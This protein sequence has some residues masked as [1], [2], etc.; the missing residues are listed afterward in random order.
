MSCPGFQLL[1]HSQVCRC[2]ASLCV[3]FPQRS[4]C[5]KRTA[6]DTARTCDPSIRRKIPLTAFCVCLYLCPWI[7][8]LCLCLCPWICFL[9]LQLVSQVTSP[10]STSFGPPPVRISLSQ[11]HSAAAI[12]CVLMAL[13]TGGYVLRSSLL[14]HCGTLC[15][16]GFDILDEH[17]KSYWIRKGIAGTLV[18]LSNLHVQFFSRSR[19]KHC[20]PCHLW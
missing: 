3:T 13:R 8:F 9:S 5:F 19:K 20:L 18:A 17:C 6:H 4:S 12:G 10:M 1:Y 15:N 7:C 2:H 14:R 16:S 11:S